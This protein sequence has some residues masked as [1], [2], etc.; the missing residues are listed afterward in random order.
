MP[1]DGRAVFVDDGDDLM[2][3]LARQMF[4]GAAEDAESVE[5]AFTQA[6]DIESVSVELL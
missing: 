5:M 4:N 1:E 2:L 3:T 6:R